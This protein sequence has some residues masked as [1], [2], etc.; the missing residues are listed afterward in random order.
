METIYES[1]ENPIANMHLRAKKPTETNALAR[2][3]GIFEYVDKHFLE[4]VYKLCSSNAVFV[5]LKCN[6]T[7]IREQPTRNI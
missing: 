2:Q 1:N 3:S 7:I 6:V 4:V 5:E